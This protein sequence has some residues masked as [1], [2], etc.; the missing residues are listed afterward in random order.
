MHISTH[1]RTYI[2]AVRQFSG[3]RLQHPDD[4]ALIAEAA[5]LHA[6]DAA[7]AELCFTAKFLHKSFDIMKRIGPHADGYGKLAS[8]FEANYAKAGDLL[9]DLAGT[10][11]DGDRERFTQHYLSLSGPALES[12]LELVHDLNWMKN[13]S[14]DAKAQT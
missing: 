7:L 11:P 3:D 1:T 14:L 9:R 8:E 12:M 5:A 6:K 2:D 13:Y 10:L 4:L